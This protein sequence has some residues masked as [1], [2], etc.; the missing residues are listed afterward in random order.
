MKHKLDFS[1]LH[2]DCPG[3]NINDCTR[4]SQIDVL[5][6]KAEGCGLRVVEQPTVHL[7][8]FNKEKLCK[9][10]CKNW[11]IDVL[12]RWTSECPSNCDLFRSD[13]QHHTEC[14]AH[15]NSALQLPKVVET[16]C[17][18]NMMEDGVAPIDAGTAAIAKKSANHQQKREVLQNMNQALSQM[19]F[20]QI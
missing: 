10:S 6:G 13:R 4:R 16:T 14:E 17:K 8:L 1:C 3:C 11:A 12:P 15:A 19:L 5:V 7:Q 18:T 9:T 20:Y 2:Y